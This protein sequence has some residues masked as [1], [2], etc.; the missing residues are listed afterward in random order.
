MLLTG[1]CNWLGCTHCWDFIQIQNKTAI[2]L[3]QTPNWVFFK[4]TMGRGVNLWEMSLGAATQ[5][6]V[7]NNS[8]YKSNFQVKGI[9]GGMKTVALFSVSCS[10]LLCTSSFSF[11][12]WYLWWKRK[13]VHVCAVL[14][15]SSYAIK[16]LML[17]FNVVHYI[18]FRTLV[19]HY[20]VDLVWWF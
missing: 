12:H 18:Y 17:S 1:E 10:N 19:R 3:V 4:C 5:L 14:Y 7:P 9:F 8:Q 11:N 16:K 20:L 15:I 2:L 13:D 6:P